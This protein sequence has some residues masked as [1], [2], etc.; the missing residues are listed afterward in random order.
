MT[1]VLCMPAA[2]LPGMPPLDGRGI[3]TGRGVAPWL[4]ALW[5]RPDLLSYVARER[6]ERDP[7]WLQL[8]PYCVVLRPDRR[9]VFRYQRGVAGGEGRLHGK[10]S[11]GVGGHVEP[12]D[13][14][15]PAGRAAYLAGYRRELAEEL[16]LSDDELRTLYSPVRAIVWDPSDDVGRVHLGLVHLLHLG[17]G[18]ALRPTDPALVGGRFQDV[19]GLLDDPG[20]WE[21]WS[22]LVIG[23][24]F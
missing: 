10:H 13:G 20:P 2:A 4:D 7:D 24:M 18:T 9:E 17:P 14:G 5:G 19:Y 12:Q 16:G 3:T 11:V 21:R 1:E 8:I 15:G 23:N 22:E 6:A